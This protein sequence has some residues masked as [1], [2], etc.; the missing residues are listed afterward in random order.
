MNMGLKTSASIEEYLEA[1][2]TLAQDG[3]TVGTTEISKRLN[4]APPSVTEMLKKLSDSGY[5][6]YLPYQGVTLTPEG[7]TLAE[8]M[9]RKHRILERFLHDVLKIGNDKVHS[10][11]CEMEH[12]LSDSTERAMCQ[13]L[14][15]PARCPDDEKVIP[16]CNFDFASCIE[17]QKWEGSN[18]EKVGN[19]RVNMTALSSLKKKQEAKIAFIRGDKKALGRLM[20][21]G[22]T[23]GTL[24]SVSRVAPLKGPLEIIVRGSRL[25]LGDDI[26]CNVFVERLGDDC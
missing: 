14:N 26:A 13:N 8:K 10:E 11:A 15:C 2:Y 3:K 18:L 24:I 19:R 17:C 16:P 7:F 9:A 1:L 25:A 5:I 4:V 21:M 12:A 22:L 6:N 20:D 23:P